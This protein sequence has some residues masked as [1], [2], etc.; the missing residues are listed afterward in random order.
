VFAAS[1]H[2]ASAQ[3]PPRHGHLWHFSSL[4]V[5]HSL[6]EPTPNIWVLSRSGY[7]SDKTIS[8]KMIYKTEDKLLKNLLRQKDENNLLTTQE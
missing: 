4:P 6:P 7:H 1:N 8:A 3:I 5:I 2:A